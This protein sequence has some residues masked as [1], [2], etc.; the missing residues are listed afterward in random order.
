MELKA[1]D[2]QLQDT[3]KEQE[4]TNLLGYKFFNYLT[5]TQE[6]IRDIENNMIPF[7]PYGVNNISNMCI[8]EV[9]TFTIE[10][11]LPDSCL[12]DALM[13]TLHES[14]TLKEF[15]VLT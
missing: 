15:E 9:K 10:Q 7:V 3:T 8:G 5:D 12:Y 1:V 13:Y 6:A 2:I 14:T 11:T 4:L